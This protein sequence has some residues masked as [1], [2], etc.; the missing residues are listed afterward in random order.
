MNT[1][2]P[3]SRTLSR[4]DWLTTGML[5]TIS[6]AAGSTAR[7]CSAEPRPN[8]SEK[9]AQPARLRISSWWLPIPGDLDAQLAFLEKAGIEGVELR[10]GIVKDP[11]KYRQALAKTKLVPTALDWGNCSAIC[12]DDAA[13]RQKSLDDLKRGIEVA[14]ELK[15]PCMI[16]VPPRLK[17]PFK[18]PDARTA[19]QI[20]LDTL[21]E[22]GALAHAAGT[23]LAI[24][25]V[26]RNNVACLH[27]VAEVAAFCRETKSPG[28]GLVADFSIMAVEETSIHGA[29]LSGGRY[30]RQVHLS[31]PHRKMPGQESEDAEL[32]LD[33]FR[34]LKAI[35]YQ[36][37]C[38]FECGMF[39]G[40]CEN[41]AASVA[42][43]KQRW[44]LA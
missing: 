25:P 37:F 44:D 8:S 35:G 11:A 1:P 21:P 42:F 36:G 39:S 29:F 34:G 30:V 13:A 31:S 43:L 22:Y 33:G 2:P 26:Q 7:L 18:A 5:G 20:L 3:L 41:L 17:S 16:V 6:L 27:T 40:F 12:S 10:G 4:R 32:F 38:S 9:A 14:H 15:A 24:E 23:C 19:R 28:I